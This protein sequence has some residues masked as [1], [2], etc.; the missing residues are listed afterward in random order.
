[1][2]KAELPALLKLTRE[3]WQKVGLENAELQIKSQRRIIPSSK[4]N[5]SYEN[6]PEIKLISL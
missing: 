1:M 3:N 2:A 6:T 4:L 5:G